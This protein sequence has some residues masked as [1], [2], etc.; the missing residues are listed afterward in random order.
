VTQTEERRH[1]WSSGEVRWSWVA[2]VVNPTT[3]ILGNAAHLREI[4]G[5]QEVEKKV[6]LEVHPETPGEVTRR[7]GEGARSS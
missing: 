6:E 4:S 2:T 1:G 7:E 5:S 3:E